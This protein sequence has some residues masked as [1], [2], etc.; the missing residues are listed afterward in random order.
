VSKAAGGVMTTVRRGEVR[1]GLGAR[2]DLGRERLLRLRQIDRGLVDLALQRGCGRF[3]VGAFGQR[4][5]ELGR[6][7]GDFALV[8]G[9]ER[10]T[11]AR[12]LDQ[13]LGQAVDLAL[14]GLALAIALGVSRR[15]VLRLALE[16]GLVRCDAL[17]PDLLLGLRGL[18]LGVGRLADT[19]GLGQ[20]L[21]LRRRRVRELLPALV[22]LAGALVDALG[23]HDGIGHETVLR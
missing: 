1:L 13:A 3:G 5:V 8:V 23:D 17:Q 7:L 14:R 2:F 22:S 4:L 6:D 16:F 12:L 11:L 21:L 19:A 20:A 18:G 10:L 9:D 15:R